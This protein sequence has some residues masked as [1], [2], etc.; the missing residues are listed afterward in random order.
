[1]LYTIPPINIAKLG[2]GLPILFFGQY[3]RWKKHFC[4]RLL[5]NPLNFPLDIIKGEIYTFLWPYDA[6]LCSHCCCLSPGKFRNESTSGREHHWKSIGYCLINIHGWWIGIIQDCLTGLWIL[7][8]PKRQNNFNSHECF[9]IGSWKQCS[10]PFV[11]SLCWLVKNGFH[12]SWI[13]II[14]SVIYI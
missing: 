6:W 4:R 10:K 9:R 2:D 7:F 13:A 14:L 1:M 5:T 8:E 11:V 3:H 12:S